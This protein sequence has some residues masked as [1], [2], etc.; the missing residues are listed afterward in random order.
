MFQGAGRVAPEQSAAYG[1]LF[2]VII[3]IEGFYMN[4]HG[5]KGFDQLSEV[6]MGSSRSWW[7]S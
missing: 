4:L 6:C 5:S 7:C 3:I 2:I 1:L